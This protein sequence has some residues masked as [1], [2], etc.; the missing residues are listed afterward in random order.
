M[1]VGP[2]IHKLDLSN[3]PGVDDIGMLKKQ[4]QHF[5]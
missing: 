5:I 2:H 1:T 4:Q 3:N